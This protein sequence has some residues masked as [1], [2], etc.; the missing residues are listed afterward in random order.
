MKPAVILQKLEA[1][2]YRCVDAQCRWAQAAAKHQKTEKA[3]AACEKA[4]MQFGAL[5]ERLKGMLITD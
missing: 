3:Y 4:E 5:L 2:H 1:A